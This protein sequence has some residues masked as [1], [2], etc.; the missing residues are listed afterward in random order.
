MHIPLP[1]TVCEADALAGVR[2]AIG[3]YDPPVLADKQFAMLQSSRMM[4]KYR[5]RKDSALVKG[6]ESGVAQSYTTWIADLKRRYHA[7]QIKAAQN[8]WS[9]NSLLNWLST[10][11]YEREEYWRIPA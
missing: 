2:A 6:N 4:K 5:Q 10:D 1:K 9:R 3:G 7:T 8:G 11:L